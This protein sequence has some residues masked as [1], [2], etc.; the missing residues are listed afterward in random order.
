MPNIG[1][2]GGAVPAGG[3]QNAVLTK[4][5][6][7]DYDAQW[8]A[9]GGGAGGGIG[10]IL[11]T[12]NWIANQ[13]TPGT[14]VN[15]SS[16]NGSVY[17]PIYFPAAATVQKLAFTVNSFASAASSTMALL[18]STAGKPGT[19][20]A[21]APATQVVNS[22]AVYTFTYSASVTAGWNFIALY[23]NLGSAHNVAAV[24]GGTATAPLPIPSVPTGLNQPSNAL[25]FVN[26][27]TIVSNPTATYVGAAALGGVP[28]L[29]CQLA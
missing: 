4:M 16:N 14:L 10:P 22:A 5:S 3:A 27:Q 11:A 9:S 25:G 29:Y 21:A 18:S 26:S 2:T 24:S 19:L 23:C 7:A 15:W 8:V 17:C 20:Y 12:G 1:S 13:L 6:T 28:L